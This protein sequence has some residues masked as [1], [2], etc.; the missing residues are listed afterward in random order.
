[1]FLTMRVAAAGITLTAA[2]IVLCATPCIPKGLETQMVGR[3]N[4]IGQTQ[5]VLFRRYVA[6]NTIEHTVAQEPDISYNVLA[7]ILLRARH[8]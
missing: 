3:A 4:R 5:D 8:S 6:H 7:S 2:N 1:M